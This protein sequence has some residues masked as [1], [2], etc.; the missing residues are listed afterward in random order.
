LKKELALVV[1]LT[2]LGGLTTEAKTINYP[3][4]K[5]PMST[6][7][8]IG[9]I[10]Y[11]YLD[12]LDGMGYLKSMLYGTRPYARVDMARWTLEA[13][14]KSKTKATPA[15]LESMI[16]E[17]EQALAP[18]IDS[19]LHNGKGNKMK[20]HSISAEAVTADYAKNSYGYKGLPGSSWQ[21]FN[22]NNNGRAYGN[23]LNLNASAY[24][25]GNLSREVA[26]SLSPR[27]GYDWNNHFKAALDEGYLATRVG[28]YKVEAGKQALDWGQGVTGKMALSNNMRPLTMLKVSSEE[29]PAFHGALSILGKTRWTGFI[30]KAAG[31]RTEY[32]VKD[33]DNPYIV[34][35]RSEMLY[36][37]LAIGMERISLLGGTGNAFR[38]SDTWDWLRGKNADHDDKWDDIAGVDVKYRFPGMQIYGELYGED[39]ANYLPSDIGYRGGLY[40]PRLSRDGKW[41]LRTEIV[42]TNTGWYSHSPYRVGWTY[43][44]NIMGDAMGGDARK[45]YMGVQHYLTAKDTIGLN[46]LYQKMAALGSIKPTVKEGWVS[47]RHKMNEAD[48]WSVLFGLAALDDLHYENSRSHTDKFVR[49]VWERRY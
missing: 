9:S 49:L 31:N 5:L 42:N 17:L 24:L 34:G 27:V 8:P 2:L 39:Q 4:T 47:Y 23:G 7:M 35:V 37:N 20:L 19:I 46:G 45:Y 18:E 22:T 25:S 44:S 3:N 21:P 38:F 28:I 11:D 30:S 6:N 1:T 32:G 36:P 12:K 26:Y 41:D 40:F 29:M 33:F 16:R 15:Y 14:E 48:T 10:Y 43:H 13:R